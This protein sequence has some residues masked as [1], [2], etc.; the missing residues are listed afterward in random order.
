MG[1]SSTKHKYVEPRGPECYPNHWNLLRLCTLHTWRKT[2]CHKWG[3]DS[4]INYMTDCEKRLHPWTMGGRHFKAV[5]GHWN[6][7]NL[8]DLSL[9][10]LQA[11][12]KEFKEYLDYLCHT[13]EKQLM[14]AEVISSHSCIWCPVI[15]PHDYSLHGL[16][17]LNETDNYIKK[18][19]VI[20]QHEDHMVIQ[21]I[22]KSQHHDFLILRQH[23]TNVR[24]FYKVQS[25]YT[26]LAKTT[27]FVM[28]AFLSPD[29][30][31]ILIKPSLH[32]SVL[33]QKSPDVNIT[34]MLESKTGECITTLFGGK[35]MGSVFAFD[36]RYHWRRLAVGACHNPNQ[37]TIVIYDLAKGTSQ[38]ESDP[39]LH[40]MTQ[41]LVFSPDGI[42]LASLVVSACIQRDVLLLEG[43]IL[44]DS[45]ELKI[46]HRIRSP[47]HYAVIPVTPIAMFPLFSIDGQYMA[48]VR[49]EDYEENTGGIDVTVHTVP[50]PKTL[51]LQDLVRVYL[52]KNLKRDH[53]SQLPLPSRLKDFLLFKPYIY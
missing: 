20:G 4:D 24:T 6:Y 13:K 34:W 44:Y 40:Q 18:M 27:P 22:R 41:N 7:G 36:P 45:D 10:D 48:A 15:K 2:E 46:L 3:F 50:T 26:L 47:G 38:V 17:S 53:I 12:S 21:V 14:I 35:A 5:I 1:G 49:S 37:R 8:D 42:Y 11:A 25:F 30:S 9:D 16:G 33:V 29:C 32:Y 52:L 19:N 31:K 43:V 28:E 23:N 39:T 51:Y